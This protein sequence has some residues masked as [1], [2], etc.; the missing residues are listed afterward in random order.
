MARSGNST[1]R[2]QLAWLQYRQRQWQ[3]ALETLQGVQ[4]ANASQRRQ[5]QSLKQAAE[6]ALARSE[7]GSEPSS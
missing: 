3:A 4:P 5:L 2:L 1:D 7:T 6:A